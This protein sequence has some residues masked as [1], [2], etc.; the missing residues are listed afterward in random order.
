MN[1]K[2]VCSNLQD[3]RDRQQPKYKLGQLVRTAVIKKVFGKGDSTNWSYLLYTITEIIHD[4]NPSYRINYLP[5]RYNQNLLQ[6]TKLT[7]VENYKVMKK[8]NLIQ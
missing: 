2:V 6:P 7:L 3:R 4:T 5:K 8:I 1:E